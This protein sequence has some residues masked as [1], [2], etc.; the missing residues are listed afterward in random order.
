MIDTGLSNRVVLITGGNHG[1]GAATAKAFVAQG[2][3]VFITYLRLSSQAYGVDPDEARRAILPGLPLY[4]ATQTRSADGV[5]G[6]IRGDAKVFLASE[7]ARWITGQVI[8]V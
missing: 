5:V 7:Q 8:K 1:I 3:R 2:A 4:H 6:E